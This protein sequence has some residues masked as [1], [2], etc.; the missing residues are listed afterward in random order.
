MNQFKQE[1]VEKCIGCVRVDG[2]VCSVYLSPAA[3][4]RNQNCPMA[5]NLIPE[6]VK[7]KKKVNPIKHSK[8]LRK[9]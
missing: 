7:E 3:K 5:T 1:I 9:R 6:K 2:E 8:R 4:W